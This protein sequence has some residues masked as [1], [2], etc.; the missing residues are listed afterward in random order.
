MKIEQR[1][2]R[3]LSLHLPLSIILIFVLF[4]FYWTLNTSLKFE[5][6]IMKVPLKYLPNPMTFQNFIETWNN[7]GFGRYF[8]NSLIVALIAVF[9]IVTFAV[10]VGYA[11]TRFRFKGKQLM[12]FLLLC[13][14]FVPGVMLLIPL[15]IIFKKLGLISNL[16]SLVIAYTTFQLPFNAIL[17]RGFIQ[18]V[19]YDI[20]EAAMMD[21]CNRLQAIFH[22]VLPILLPGIIATAAFAFISCWNEFIFALM[23]ISRSDL[24]TIPVALHSM[25]GEYDINYGY[26]AAGSII[27][28]IPP[29]LMFAYV[30][31]YLVQ[32]LSAGS[33]KG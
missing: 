28:M 7:I 4:P 21:G 6:D 12:M 33:V 3:C 29:F 32:G 24:Y 10:L 5:R 23:F 14:Q 8:R 30:Q 31:K 22:V 15:F 9:F 27:A 20:E 26:L 11:L 18:N 19:P 17:M 1:L 13:T 16:G 25:Q 2:R